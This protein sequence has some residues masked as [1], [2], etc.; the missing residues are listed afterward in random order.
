MGVFLDSVR[1]RPSDQ[2]VMCMD[3]DTSG[4]F[5]VPTQLRSTLLSVRP[6][7]VLIRPRATVIEA[8]DPLDA[9][10]TMLAIEQGGAKPGNMFDG[11]QFA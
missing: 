10:I 3:K 2:W 4:G 9:C 11:M 8:G 5:M 6:Q 7:D 1:F